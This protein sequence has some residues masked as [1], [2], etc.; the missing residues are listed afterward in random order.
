[1]AGLI[2]QLSSECHRFLYSVVF[3][4]VMEAVNN[5]DVGKFG[6]RSLPCEQAHAQTPKSRRIGVLNWKGNLCF[7]GESYQLG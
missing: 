1:M 6:P 4:R 3:K 2:K 5:V 7:L